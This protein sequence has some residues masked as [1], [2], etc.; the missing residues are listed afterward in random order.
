[1]VFSHCVPCKPSEEHNGHQGQLPESPSEQCGGSSS[2]PASGNRGGFLQGGSYTSSAGG[3]ST[4]P[5]GTVR[6]YLRSKMPRLRWTADLHHC[7][8]HAVERLGGQE[9][10]T[11]K[12]VLQLMEVKGLTIA[13][14]KSHLQ[15]YRSMKNDENGH[16]SSCGSSNM[17]GEQARGGAHGEVAGGG[18]GL[19]IGAGW[20]MSDVQQKRAFA[21]SQVGCNHDDA[22]LDVYGSSCTPSDLCSL[23]SSTRFFAQGSDLFDPA[24]CLQ[25]GMEHD[26]EP[27]AEKKSRFSSGPE[28]PQPIR[29]SAFQPPAGS[30]FSS[31]RKHAGGVQSTD[32]R[33]CSN[34]DQQQ[35]DSTTS[36]SLSPY[37]S[38]TKSYSPPSWI[39]RSFS[40]PP[41][42][43][44]EISDCLSLQQRESAAAVQV[45]PKGITLDLTMSI[46]GQ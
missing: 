13:H 28:L 15:M 30:W 37:S 22:R 17:Q 23:C 18:R 21:Q 43:N 16:N 1:M 38:R 35:L 3:G 34:H 2:S 42:T 10:A 33:D 8:V 9:R 36:L 32:E 19:V 31:S 4:R 39:T 45:P 25:R 11:P 20:G 46:G 29:P 12:L 41:G 5:G 6:Q 26:A 14:V 7:F 24:H 40:L 44:E 27:G